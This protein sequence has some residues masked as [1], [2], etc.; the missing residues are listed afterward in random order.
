M[1]DL[2][3]S[4]NEWCYTGCGH[5]P[6]HWEAL[7]GSHCGGDKQSPIDIVTSIVTTDQMLDIFTFVNFSS[8]IKTITNNGHSVQCDIEENEAE[9][10]GGG[11]NGQYSVLQFHFHWGTKTLPGSEHTLNDHHYPME[12]HIVMTKKG[13]PVNETFD[14]EDG[15]A[16]LGFFIDVCDKLSTAY[17]SD[18]EGS[19]AKVNHSISIDD[20]I[21][22]V[23][24]SKFYRYMGSLTTP[25]CNEAVVWTLFHEPI[26]VHKELLQRFPMNTNITNNYRPVQ[27]L[28]GRNITASPATPLLPAHLWCY[29]DHCDCF[30]HFLTPD[31]TPSQWADLSDSHCGGESQSPID[32]DTHSVME[33]EHLSSFTF[34]N[35]DNKHAIKSIINTGH[36]VKCVLEDDLVEVSGGGLDHIYSTLQ[37]HFHWGTESTDSKGSEHTVDSERYPMEMH[38]V[39][40]RKDLTL[41]KAI[42]TP[43]GLAVLGFFIEPPQ[44]IKSSSHSVPAETTGPTLSP[45]YNMEAWKTLTYYLSEIKNI[46]SEVEVTDEISIDD[47]LGNV[48][49]K[50]YFRYSGSLTTPLCNEA[51]VW[52]VFKESVKVDQDLMA[53]FPENAGY[54]NVFRPRQSLHS[55]KVYTTAAAAVPG[56]ILFYLLLPCFCAL[57]GTVKM[58]LLAVIAVAVCILAPSAYCASDAIA[59]CYHDKS[60]NDTTWPTIAA[61]YCNG[62]RQSPIDIV[63]ENATENANLTDFTFVGYDNRSALATIENTGKTVKVNFHSGVRISGG[64]LSE[65]Y[66][67][68]QFHLHWG[69]GTSIPGSEHTVDGK[70]FPMELHIVNSKSSYNGNTTLAIAD[71]EGLAALGFFIEEL[72][73]TEDQPASWKTLTSYLS[74][75]TTAGG[76]IEIPAG[77]SLDDLLSGVDRSSY[78]RYL[79]SLTTPSCNEA[80]VWTVFKQS[81]K[82][83]KNLIDHFSSTVRI[84]NSTSA[85]MVNVYRGIQPSQSVS[86]QPRSSS[87]KT[88]YSLALIALTLVMARY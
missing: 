59:W 30:E 55:R 29:D 15:L 71:S 86:T 5:T 56:P 42:Q 40:K 58:N 7:D 12:M 27:P 70:R 78:Y 66:D 82:V 18:K 50:S 2:G 49:R 62:T 46:S 73:N 51:V 60:C 68:L 35:F 13:V 32:I 28:H 75:I 24:R 72:P 57:F 16:V 80:V 65:S 11:L 67:S 45:E 6:E 10:S 44:S 1:S 79:G 87:T 34:T 14:H 38:I 81:I 47:L 48:N 52:T 83:S 37:F 54:H 8:A 63:S 3:G 21:R 76:K 43:D 17:S 23:D 88:G 25:H 69:N 19:T 64:D 31:H 4:G 53:M 26:Q 61:Q 41:D 85:L 20:L 36:T 22:D 74:N 9:V 39:N 77:I 84:N 33:D